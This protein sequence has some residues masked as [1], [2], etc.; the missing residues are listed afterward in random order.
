MKHIN[1][2]LVNT[3]EL[4][5]TFLND[6]K[7]FLGYHEWT[8]DFEEGIPPIVDRDDPWGSFKKYTKL[9][10]RYCKYESKFNDRLL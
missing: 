2:F 3:K 9:Y 7:C 1:T 5:K 8:S 10:C 4:L 6:C